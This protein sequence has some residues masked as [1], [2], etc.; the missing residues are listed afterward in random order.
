MKNISLSLLNNFKS[1]SLLEE[2]QCINSNVESQI[3][4]LTKLKRYVL[5]IENNATIRIKSN[6]L[7]ERE[8][9]KQLIF[10]Y[11]GAGKTHVLWSLGMYLY[12]E[13]NIT[14]VY[15]SLR[16]FSSINEIENYLNLLKKGL[17]FEVLNQSEN[18]IFL[19]DGLT[20]FSR[21]KQHKSELKKLFSLLNSSK[22]IST[23]RSM[24]IISGC[25][26]W[27]LELID[28]EQVTRFIIE[29]GYDIEKIDE[30][31][32]ELLSY[33][34]LLILYVILGGKSTST[35]ELFTEYFNQ[36]S[37]DIDDKSM[38]HKILSLSAM[39]MDISHE[40]MKWAVF[41]NKFH[42]YCEKKNKDNYKPL[43]EKLGLFNRRGVMLE[44]LHD[45][46][47]EWLVGCGLIFSW[48]EIKDEVIENLRVRNKLY[49]SI[50]SPNIVLPIENELLEIIYLD[51]VL[52]S[53]FY[54][55]IK[56]KSEY[57][58]FCS[59]FDK[60]LSNK[61]NSDFKSEKIRAIKASFISRNN[62]FLEKTLYSLNE[63]ATE[64]F[65]VNNIKEYIS[66]EF[67]W[68]NNELISDFYSLNDNV[69]IIG[70]VIED[71]QDI[72]WAK[73]AEDLYLKGRLRFK[74]AISIYFACSN[75]LPE[76][77]K[78]DLF[79]FL[80]GRNN[81]CLRSA[82]KK[83]NNIELAY[84]LYENYSDLIAID[85]SSRWYDINKILIT[86]SERKLIEIIS[87]NFYH[88]S[89]RAQELMLYV[90]EEVDVQCLS[91]LGNNLLSR[92]IEHHTKERIFLLIADLL[93]DGI[94][95]QWA[96]SENIDI[97]DLGWSVLTKRK[98]VEILDELI[99]ELPTTFSNIH[100]IPTLRAMS[101]IEALPSSLE[102]V[103]ISKLDSPMMPMATHDYIV[104]MGNVQPNGILNILNL[105][106]RQPFIFGCYHFR[107][108]AKIFT[109]WS[110]DKGVKVMINYQD[111]HF[112]I[113]EY[114]LLLQLS[115]SKTDEWFELV[116]EYAE[117]NVLF[118]KLTDII[119][120]N[121]FE[122][123]CFS[124]KKYFKPLFD[125]IKEKFDSIT[126]FNIHR[127]CLDSLPI[128]E[129]YE[130]SL[131]ILQ[132]HQ[133]EISTLLFKLA[134][135]PNVKHIDIYREIL[136]LTIH[137][138]IGLECHSYVASLFSCLNRTQVIDEF[139][140]YIIDRKEISIL[141]IRKIELLID[142][143]LINESYEFINHEVKQGE[144]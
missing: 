125:V 76:W 40:D 88:L 59:L 42:Q 61:L 136:S 79:S 64:R 113:I 28:K 103:L 63:L 57:K 141:L 122:K 126:V 94:L 89:T 1:H 99:A 121:T 41:E 54:L 85:S 95:R 140:L 115:S 45:L 29:S 62:N 37:L 87:D 106:Q 67:L 73:W 20:E 96:K 46:Y 75:D 35:S 124:I 97:S 70:G 144:D 8:N 133:K 108:F 130:L 13:T 21:N 110:K 74:Y 117:H 143:L 31:L 22:T 134:S 53:Y 27:N 82:T 47:W 11:G 55:H 19:L 104:A 90:L 107:I 12:E 39:D 9:S 129:L 131:D 24:N 92:E 33:P 109:L 48:V 58:V 50:N 18:I 84:W 83:G 142:S 34:L 30:P 71:T 69:Y 2:F 100:K 102:A 138:H 49:L 14:P 43:L 80:S 128:G 93:D 86:C 101:K 15:I 26:N 116:V 6:D 32:F 36:L 105:I 51:I 139:S 135:K 98:G 10:A 65:D 91:S 120:V 5:K 44:P 23:S 38:L 3:N 78:I 123:L 77:I 81:H 4:L 137:G 17:S 25:E 72:K 132:H 52:S 119:K 118:L 66:S 56:N 127:D 111:N 114:Y 7:V 112:N 60:E 16:D 68:E